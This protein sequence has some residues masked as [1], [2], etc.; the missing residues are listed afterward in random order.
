MSVL[1]FGFDSTSLQSTKNMMWIALTV[2]HVARLTDTLIFNW[3]VRNHCANPT[4]YAWRFS[5]GI[6]SN[7]I[8]W[9]VYSFLLVA[10][11]PTGEATLTAVFL[12]A[13]AGGAIT[14]LAASTIL[15]CI[16]MSALL[17]PFAIMGLYSE[18]EYFSYISYLGFGFWLVM[19]MSASEAGRFLTD[20]LRLK[21]QNASLLNM[22]DLE[23][24]EVERVNNELTQANKKLDSYNHELAAK[25]E[26][27]TNEIYRLSNID[28]LT[29]L[30]NR[31]AFTKELKA[32]ITHDLNSPTTNSLIL[33]F[34]DLD[35][36]KDVNDGFGHKVGDS[37]LAEIA[38]RLE[39][40]KTFHREDRELDQDS[41][42]P[43]T[44][45]LMCRWGGD[46][47]LIVSDNASEQQTQALITLIQ[48]RIHE[49]ILVAS[50]KITLGASIGTC[51]YPQDS[52]H[53]TELIQYADISMYRHKKLKQGHSV[54][55][56]AHL[57]TA[58]QHEQIIRD[59]LKHAIAKGEYS[60]VFHPIIDVQDDTLWALEALIRWQHKGN[61]VPPDEFISIAE[62][63]GHMIEIGNWVLL[64][65]CRQAAQWDFVPMPAVSVNVSALQLL[66]EKFIDTIDFAIQESGLHPNRLHIEIT[67]SVMLDNNQLAT[68]QLRAIAERG[69]HV[70]IDDFG[71]GY[72]SLNQLQTMSFDI[73][74]IDRS[75]LQ[76]LN[77]KDITIIS[78]TKLIADEFNAVTVAEGIETE[79]ELKVLKE[80]GIRYIQGYLFAKPMSLGALKEWCKRRYLHKR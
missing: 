26:I 48:N 69:I 36:F 75:F 44:E 78:A 7:S 72:S 37:V 61:N 31:A 47:F 3:Q 19:L 79:D 11:L 42:R 52:I 68:C 32:L 65:A 58:F 70:S 4:H 30:M 17:L 74:K 21:N 29:N 50:N 62:K 64:N 53:T 45:N 20:V 77:S 39:S 10:S 5:A 28:P 27:R 14:I 80:I 16:Y 59:G 38:L 33:L 66:D 51:R 41:A 57:F 8:I 34:I 63:S 56:S 18:V 22:M 54:P 25:V 12:S 67:E 23:K 1:C 55:F 76:D 71:T 6:L 73:I 60:L 40:V 35:G 43:F 46:E 13:L 24:K 49:P 15:S 2:S 9:S